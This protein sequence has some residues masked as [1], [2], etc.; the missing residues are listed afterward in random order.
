VVSLKLGTFA[1][2]PKL[3]SRNSI[4]LQMTTPPYI[5]DFQFLGAVAGEQHSPQ[6][7]NTSTGKTLG[8]SNPE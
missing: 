4:G 2:I 8:L 3:C 1:A 7:S 6:T 5:V